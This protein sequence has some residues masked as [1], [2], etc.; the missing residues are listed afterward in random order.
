LAVQ[1]GGTISSI[2][3]FPMSYRIANAFASYIIYVRK[4]LWPSNLA[5]FYPHLGLW[6]VWQ[7]LGAVL[8]L[9]AVTLTVIWKAERLPYLAMGWLWYVGTLVPVIGIMQVGEQAMAD[10]YTYIPLIGLFIMAAWGIPGLLKNWRYQKEVL[11]ALA[12]LCLL[13]LLI[14][15]RTQVGHWQNSITLFD[16]TLKVTEHN[17]FVYNNRGAVYVDLGNYKQAISDYDRAIEINPNYAEAYY[18]RGIPYI[19]LGNQKQAIEDLKTAARLGLEH[20]KNILRS[21][22][23]N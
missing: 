23:I 18:N 1:K 21:Y 8:I 14:V 5:V 20:S 22:G 15:T 2:D 13:C 12:T 4:M 19:R 11:F 16:H 10:R 7:I 6:P 9:I 17:Y 3:E